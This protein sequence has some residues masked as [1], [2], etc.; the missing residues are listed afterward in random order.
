MNDQNVLEEA[1]RHEGTRTVVISRVLNA[2][3]TA[4]RDIGVEA[5]HSKRSAPAGRNCAARLRKSGI[6][7][8]RSSILL[9]T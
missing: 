8:N 1:T 2:E 6:G 3:D 9:A 4:T 7:L 5:V